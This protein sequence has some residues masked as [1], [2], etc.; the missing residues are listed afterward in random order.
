MAEFLFV[1]IIDVSGVQLFFPW[2]LG[3]MLLNDG[4]IRRVFSQIYLRCGDCSLSPKR[5]LGVAI[6]K[7]PIR[8][9]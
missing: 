2:A 4:S 9:H 8:G 7:Q 5:F 6:E 1:Q 3:S